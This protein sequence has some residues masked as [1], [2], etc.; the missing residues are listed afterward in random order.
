MKNASDVGVLISCNVGGIA[1]TLR[2][3]L[4]GMGVRRI[5]LA[6]SP[7]QLDEGF[8]AVEPS[9]LLVYVDSEAETDA[10][11]T[12]L[13]HVRRSADSLMPKIPVVA[14]SQRRD[15]ATINTVMNAGAHEYVL[16]PASGDVLLKRVM[17]AVNS[18]RPFIETPDYVGPE[19]KIVEVAKS[20]KAATAS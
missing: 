13:R 12:T 19:R 20:A 18:T 6:M 8:A 5:F 3:A 2:M 14:V 10:G 7:D 11:L 1:R 4:R 9:V 17:A 16:F 15:L